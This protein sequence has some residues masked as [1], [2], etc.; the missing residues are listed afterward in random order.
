MGQLIFAGAGIMNIIQEQ[1][2]EEP[3]SRMAEH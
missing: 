3:G 2:G 1:N